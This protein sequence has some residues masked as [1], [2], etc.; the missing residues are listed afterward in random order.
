MTQVF[1]LVK[2]TLAIIDHKTSSPSYKT[3]RVPAGITNI[4]VEWESTGLLN[5]Q[6]VMVF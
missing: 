5:E 3:L 1:L 2:V 4:I 6:T